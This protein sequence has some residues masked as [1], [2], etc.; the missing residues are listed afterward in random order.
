M[1]NHD[2][3]PPFGEYF[4]FFQPPNKQVRLMGFSN[5]TIHPVKKGTCQLI[6]EPFLKRKPDHLPFP[7][8]P[9]GWR[10]GATPGGPAED[11][12]VVLLEQWYHE[13]GGRNHE[14]DEI[15]L[16]PSCGCL[17]QHSHWR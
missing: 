15:G 4:L 7:G 12:Q 10:F 14:L 8:G 1:I 9:V 3:S 13:L 5:A 17:R 16:H 2:V 11:P 6:K